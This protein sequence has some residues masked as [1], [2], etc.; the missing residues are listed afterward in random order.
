LQWNRDDAAQRQPGCEWSRAI[1]ISHRR[2]AVDAMPFYSP[3][4]Y[5][6]PSLFPFKVPGIAA[7]LSY[8]RMY[9]TTTLSL[10]SPPHRFS[11]SLPLFRDSRNQVLPVGKLPHR[12]RL[13]PVLPF[14]PSCYLKA[15]ATRLAVSRP[16]D[17]QRWRKD[18][19][20]ERVHCH[21]VIGAQKS[22]R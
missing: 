10:P 15:H 1:L 4:S 5:S 21:L 3:F 8:S 13:F 20:C 6:L 9:T 12:L 7:L 17:Y 14:V 2:L 18:A 22:S 19:T 16:R 11:S